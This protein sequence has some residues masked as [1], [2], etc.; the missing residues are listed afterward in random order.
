[1]EG[2]YE[3]ETLLNLRAEERLEAEATYAEALAEYHE[4][5]REVEWARE[6]HR[7]TREAR[8]ALCKGFDEAMAKGPTRSGEV[9]AFQCHL[10]S[11]REIE[12][13]ARD[14]VAR[15]HQRQEAAQVRMRQRHEDMLLAV[16]AL[17]AVERHKEEWE[18][19]REVVTK[20]SQAA[21]M[22]EI[23]ARLWRESR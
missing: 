5:G 23:S 6:E 15:A 10:E 11:L 12:E 13:E 21:E 9:Q 19:E 8:R 18:A 2:P 3:L 20:R 1:M 7:R 17:Q 14:R 22:D 4:A 16:R